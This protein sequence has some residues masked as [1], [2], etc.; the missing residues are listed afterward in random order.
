MVRNDH[1]NIVAVAFTKNIIKLMARAIIVKSL[2]CVSIFLYG[3]HRLITEAASK[4][5]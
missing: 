2:V 1:V 4:C 5:G 3:L